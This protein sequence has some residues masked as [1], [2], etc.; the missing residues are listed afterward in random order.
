MTYH[1]RDLDSVHPRHVTFEPLPLCDPAVGWIRE[2]NEALIDLRRALEDGV[3]GTRELEDLLAVRAA[4]L[5]EPRVRQDNGTDHASAKVAVTRRA[6]VVAAVGHFS[7]RLML[8]VSIEEAERALEI[9]PL[10]DS[11][12]E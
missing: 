11:S 6:N 5:H 1:P 3:V 8:Q 9:C 7:Y 4:I 10:F 12:K 2:R